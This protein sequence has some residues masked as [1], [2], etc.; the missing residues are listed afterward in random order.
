LG[1]GLS[2]AVG[3][4]GLYNLTAWDLNA[5]I[6]VYTLKTG[7]MSSHEEIYKKVMRAVRRHFT[8]KIL[9]RKQKTGKF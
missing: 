6:I 2:H 9:P 4:F 5:F 3:Y 7:L 8:F 1:P